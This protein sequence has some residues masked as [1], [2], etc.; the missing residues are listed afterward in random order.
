M[1]CPVLP[2]LATSLW[3]NG[4]SGIMDRL[5][6]CLED[7][8]HPCKPCSG[9]IPHG[10]GGMCPLPSSTSSGHHIGTHSTSPSTGRSWK[11][12]R[13]MGSSQGWVGF[14]LLLSILAGHI[15]IYGVKRGKE[16]CQVALPSVYKAT[17][18]LQ[19]PVC[20]LF[21]C[22]LEP[23]EVKSFFIR[24]QLPWDGPT[25]AASQSNREMEFFSQ[26]STRG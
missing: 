18:T 9:F 4:S 17:R 15:F 13:S 19:N 6:F 7:S 10:T 24:N 22:S 11:R 12:P 5:L 16:R 25:C 26:T 3:D 1:T 14:I 8:S 21:P 2:N 23:P 20:C